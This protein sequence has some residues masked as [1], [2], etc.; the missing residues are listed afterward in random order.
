MK[1]TTYTLLALLI[2]AITSPAFAQIPNAGF[3]NWDSLTLVNNVRIYNPDVWNSSNIEQFNLNGT[4]TVSM[5]TDAHTGKYA[6]KLVSAKDDQDLQSTF[7]S[8]GYSIGEGA[9][10]PGADKFPLKGRINGFEGYYKYFPLEEDSFRVFL[11]LYRNGQYLGQAFM[12]LGKPADTYTKFTWPV[13]FPSSIP[14]PDSAKFIIEPSIFDGSEGS[15]LYIDDLNITYGFATATDEVEKMPEIS[16][17][18]NPVNDQMTLLGFDPRHRHRYTIAAVDGKEVAA[19]DLTNST[20]Q[21]GF[22]DT[23]LYILTL[24]NDEGRVSRLR[25]VK[26]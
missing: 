2:G 9:N 23:G 19:G 14:A 7:L 13:N 17:F 4:Q 6:V 21:T 22:L 15:V 10:D 20:L 5:T 24:I 8:S 25:F 26:H 16:L 18:P 3:E 1:R 12:L 11:A